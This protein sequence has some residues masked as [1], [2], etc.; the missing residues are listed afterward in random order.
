MK[1]IYLAGKVTGLSRMEAVIKFDKKEKEL[2]KEGY[3]V[4]NPLRLANPKSSWE[5]AMKICIAALMFCDEAYFM[6][7]WIK[8]KGASI[9]RSLAIELNIPCRFEFDEIKNATL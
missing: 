3:K 8:S 5:E 4:V 9:E 2:I 6:T 1:R 7:C